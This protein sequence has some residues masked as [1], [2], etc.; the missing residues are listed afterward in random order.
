MRTHACI[1]WWLPAAGMLLLC[2]AATPV[3]GQEP[4][5][6]LLPRLTEMGRWAVGESDQP[7]VLRNRCIRFFH[8]PTGVISDPLGADLDSDPPP[9]D[10][11]A[12]RPAA[13]AD[14]LDLPV[15]AALFQDNPYFD[16]Q[17]PGDVGGPGYYHIYTQVQLF[18]NE[19]TA[20]SLGLQAVTPAGLENDGLADGPTAF[21][22]NLALVHELFDGLAVEGF[23]GKNLR[24]RSGWEDHW[25]HSLHYGVALAHPL[26]GFDRDALPR[27]DFFVETLGRYR[28]DGDVRPGGPAV[29]EV[30]PGLHWHVADNC[31]L[32]GGVLMPLTT[33]RRDPGLW[34]LTCSWQF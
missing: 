5:E 30:L 6:P 28:V 32:T 14:D 16:F 11:D 13:D 22:P 3:A 12:G 25:G 33:L 31:W 19:T 7:C 34:Q 20:C 10:A 1:A 4:A 24:A 17:R 26:P 29:W 23:V 9:G 18:A 2:L 27:V 21:Y 8:M 15:Q